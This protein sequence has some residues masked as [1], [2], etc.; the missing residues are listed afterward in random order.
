M[1]YMLAEI[2]EIYVSLGFLRKFAFQIS[3]RISMEQD[4]RGGDFIVE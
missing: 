2:Y 4:S 3:K 1:R